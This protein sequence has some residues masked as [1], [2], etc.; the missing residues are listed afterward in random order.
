MQ[1]L[2]KRPLKAIL[3][4]DLID[5]FQQDLKMKGMTPRPRGETKIFALGELN[6]RSLAPFPNPIELI[7]VQNSSGYRLFFGKVKLQDGRLRNRY[8]QNKKH[9]LRV[10]NPHYQSLEIDVTL[11]QPN[12]PLSVKLMPGYAYSFPT[13]A[14]FSPTLIRGVIH[15]PNGNGVA[16]AKVKLGSQTYQTDETGQWVF[17]VPKS[18]PA[19]QKSIRVTFPDKSTRTIKVEMAHDATNTVPATV[20]HS[21]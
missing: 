8:L 4:F 14:N 5:A 20:W 19:G 1:I 11:P 6:G 2:E 7:T 13:A 15:N 21:S 9:R 18:E 3:I 16:H 10:V 17:V 12:Q